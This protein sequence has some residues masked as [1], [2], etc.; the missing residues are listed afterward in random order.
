MEQ[1]MGKKSALHVF[2]L[3]V[4]SGKPFFLFE[5]KGDY[6]ATRNLRSTPQLRSTDYAD[7]H[8]PRAPEAAAGQLKQ[9]G[10]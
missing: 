8:P 10:G 3:F 9:A 5:R 7:S 1:H 2:S 6:K 4:A